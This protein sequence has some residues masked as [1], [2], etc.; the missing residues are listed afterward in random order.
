MVCCSECWGVRR[1]VRNPVVKLGGRKESVS[2]ASM[3][4]PRGAFRTPR[5]RMSSLPS[6][7]LAVAT[8]TRCCRAYA[9]YLLFV[10]HEMTRDR[11]RRA[12]V[13][14][15]ATAYHARLLRCFA[16]TVQMPQL[17]ILPHTPCLSPPPLSS[18]RYYSPLLSLPV[19]HA[20][21]CVCSECS[22]TL[23]VL[24]RCYHVHHFF[25]QL[26]NPSKCSCRNVS[27]RAQS[28]H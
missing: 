28:L 25:Q 17:T 26:T 2:C 6:T 10:Y 12:F 3:H 21:H 18:S 24:R 16:R 5:T 20:M 11:T 23:P 15:R 14:I 4:I 27:C 19:I 13:L 1:P 9:C 8:G 7:V 22:C